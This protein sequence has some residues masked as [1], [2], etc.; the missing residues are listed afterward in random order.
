M[1]HLIRTSIPPSAQLRLDLEEDLPAIEADPSQVQQILMNLVINA[2]EAITAH[3]EIGVRTGQRE[4][5]A[6]DISETRE[7]AGLAPGRYVFLEV[8]DTGAGMDEE[9][10]SKIFDP[11]FTTKFTGRGLG[12]AA[13]A[14]IV[15]SHRGAIQVT[16]APGEGS[17]FC[18][19]LPAVNVPA[20]ANRAPAPQ[21]SPGSGIILVAD[22]EPLVRKTAT[23]ALERY[24]Y[25]VLSAENGK[26]AIE[27]LQ[28]RGD[29]IAVILLDMA[30]P[31]MSGEEAFP[32]L[33]R[34]QPDV[35]IVI[36]SG[37]S[38]QTARERFGA[39][40]VEAFI[41]KPYTGVEL[42]QK[43]QAALAKQK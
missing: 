15:R 36:S 8:S 19:Y 14:G 7:F 22:D 24:G 26:E 39:S 20:P 23:L 42:V 6:A 33:K 9:T 2:G 1:L 31:V 11:F 12:L 38:E 13:V 35:A 10:R 37:Y 25:K 41:Q 29:E 43:I 4:I 32:E 34:I 30:M 3:G 27:M 21:V 17:K 28:A 18:I 40:A 5:T 16:S